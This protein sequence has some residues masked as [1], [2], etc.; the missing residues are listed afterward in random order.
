MQRL[1]AGE[2][3]RISQWCIAI[4]PPQPPPN[5]SS[6]GWRIKFHTIDVQPKDSK[7]CLSLSVAASALQCC[8][9]LFP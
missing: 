9:R 3:R 5:D 8:Y 1:R 6:I 4:W 2:F 7:N